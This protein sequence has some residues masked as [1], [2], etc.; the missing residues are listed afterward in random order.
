ML[1]EA[2]LWRLLPPPSPP[3]T[4]PDRFWGFWRKIP[5]WLWYVLTLL[6]LLITLAGGFPWLSIA[7]GDRLDPTN[8]FSQMFVAKNEG[9]IPIFEPEVNCSA[10]YKLAKDGTLFFDMAFQ[11]GMSVHSG[12]E[13]GGTFSVPCD[14]AKLIGANHFPGSRM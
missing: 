1:Q 2:G 11:P 14:S 8:P 4:V 3:P 6:G 9:L 13:H 12:I 10:H 5:K 7:Q